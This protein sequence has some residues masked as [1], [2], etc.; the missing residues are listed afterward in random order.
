M[1]LRLKENEIIIYF[2]TLVQCFR[3]GRIYLGW[4]HIQ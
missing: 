1:T 4:K 2:Q 3:L